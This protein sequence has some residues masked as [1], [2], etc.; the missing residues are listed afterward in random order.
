ME[1]D[2]VPTHDASPPQPPKPIKDWNNTF[3]AAVAASSLHP[4]DASWAHSSLHCG[5]LHA[6]EQPTV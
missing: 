1:D 3:A 4:M 6:D 5:W 2:E